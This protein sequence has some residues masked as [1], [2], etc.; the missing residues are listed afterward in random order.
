MLDEIGML[1]EK[2]HVKEIMDDAGTFPVGNWLKEF[3]LGMIKRGYNKKIKF[4]CNMRL[5]ALTQK[6]Y[7]LMGKAGFRFILYGLESANQKTLDRINKNLKVGMI[8]ETVRRA[9]KAGLEPHI[10]AM[11]GYPWETKE[12]AKKTVQLAKMLFDKGYVDTLQ[13]TI[14]IPYPGTPL[15]SECKENKWLVTEDWDDFDQRMAVMKS[16]LTEK[17]IKELTQELYKSFLTPKFIL[18]K[19]FSIRSWTDIKFLF[20]A[21]SKVMGHLLDFK[22][23]K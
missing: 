17:D 2:Y 3:C 15:F 16:P 19:I 18:R 4:D 7:D 14:L 21:G 5:N 23:K 22:T 6:E 12:E 9:K 11:M 13:A 20:R 1:I 10:T 8:E